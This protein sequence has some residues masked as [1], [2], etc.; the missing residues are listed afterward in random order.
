M[1]II[2]FVPE[3]KIVFLKLA[4][5]MAFLNIILLAMLTAA[6][7]RE[8]KMVKIY[9]MIFQFQS[10]KNKEAPQ[11]QCDSRVFYGRSNQNIR[12]NNT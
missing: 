11:R 8:M 1:L 5:P 9:Y 6:K 2:F 10:P 3:L 7:A 4:K 12:Y